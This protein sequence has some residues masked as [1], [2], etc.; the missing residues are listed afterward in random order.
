LLNSVLCAHFTDHN[1]RGY[2]HKVSTVLLDG[3]SGGERLVVSI[4]LKFTLA[5]IQLILLD[6]Y[7]MVH[8]ND[9]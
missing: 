6:K 1:I 5:P 2:T 3:Q 7:N 8:S 9:L 4:D